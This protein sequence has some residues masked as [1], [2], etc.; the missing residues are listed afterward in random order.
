[1]P[2][3]N[4]KDDGIYLNDKLLFDNNTDVKLIYNCL[5]E[6]FDFRETII[7]TALFIEKAILIFSLLSIL[8]YT[9]YDLF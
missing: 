7:K 2:K 9:F 3:V 6:L 1:M 8:A 4:F 5:I